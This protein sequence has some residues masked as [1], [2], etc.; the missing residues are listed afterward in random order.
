M[1]ALC[2]TRPSRAPIILPSMSPSALQIY[3]YM[4]IICPQ[5]PSHP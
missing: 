3:I 4:L 5:A 1:F 2:A